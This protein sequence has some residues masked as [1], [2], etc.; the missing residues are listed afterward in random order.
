M[1]GNLSEMGNYTSLT[2][3]LLRM[4]KPS[5]ARIRMKDDGHVDKKKDKGGSSQANK[6][7]RLVPR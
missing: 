6:A 5:H 1:V 4:W 3:G 7:L 2:T